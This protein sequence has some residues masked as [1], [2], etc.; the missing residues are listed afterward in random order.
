VKKLM[1]NIKVLLRGIS[2]LFQIE[3]RYAILHIVSSLLSPIQ[4]YI[5][6]YMVS[7]ILNELSERRDKTVL[8]IYIGITIAANFIFKIVISALNMATNYRS[9]QFYKNEKMFFAQKAMTMDFKD[10]EST[11]IHALLERIQN[12]SQNGYNMYYLIKF[13]GQLIS[14]IS[15]VVTSVSLSLN[16]II[17]HRINLYAKMGLLCCVVLVIVLTYYTTK[18]TN[19]KTLDMYESLIPCNVKYNF[20]NDYNEDYNVGKDI[21]IYNLQN[22]VLGIQKQQIDFSTNLLIKTKKETLKYVFI[23]TF[24]NHLLKIGVYVFVFFACISGS[25]G[26]GDITRYVSCITLLVITAGELISQFQSLI[27]NNKYL[28][29]YFQYFDI[30]SSQERKGGIPVTGGKHEFEFKNV[31]FRYPNTKVDALKN[32]S[33]KIHSGERISVVGMNG[34]GKTTMI[35]LL[36]RLYEPC[37]GEILLD[38]INIKEYIYNDYMRLLGVIFQ[39]FKIFSFSLGQNI[40]VSDNMDRQSIEIVLKKAGLATFLEKLPFGIETPLYRDFD[41][42]GLEISGGEAQKIALARVLYKDAAIMILDEPTAALDPISENDIYQRFNSVVEDKSVIYIS[43]RLAS[44][45]FCDRILVFSEGNLVQNGTH[46]ELVKNKDGIY[47]K[48]W[49]AQAQYYIK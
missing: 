31:T 37:D 17:D 18:K 35:K 30:P 21:R 6:I 44:C 5:N 38:G 10:V 1:Q 13:S 49:N 16:L 9:G 29:R 41:E 3:K 47:F 2:Y 36:C 15:S 40:V 33:F 14:S 42:R 39:D 20:Y 26:V 4:P 25:V 24:V 32:I 11:E 27:N 48:L 46:H 45:T 19:K 8:L 12:E 7:I 28:E 43:H 23:S 22:Y 34:S